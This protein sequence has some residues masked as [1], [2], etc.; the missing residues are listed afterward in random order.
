[1]ASSLRLIPADELGALP[2]TEILSGTR[3][4]S[5]GLNVIFGASGAF[6]SFYALD[7]ALTVAQ[8]AP[9]VYVAAEGAGGLHRRVTSWC[10]YN[11]K[12][13]GQLF[14]ICKEINLLESASVKSLLTIT[15]PVKPQL[16]VFD[17]L[18]RCIP[19]GDEN[20]AKD[21]GI[22]IQNSAVVQRE[23]NTAV[24]WVHHTNRAERGER[25]SGAIRG[26]ADAM[27]EISANG[28]NVIRVACSKL[29]D[30]EPWA[31]EELQFHS[32][33]RS[34]VLVPIGEFRSEKLSA[35][36]YQILDFLAL[37]VF[38]TSGAKA[39][40]IVNGVNIPERKIYHILSHLKREL[41]ISHDSK[42]DPYRLTESGRK[43]V[44]Q[45]TADPAKILQLV[46]PNIVVG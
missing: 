31:M 7:A 9:V 2:P 34:G 28:D 38:E 14:F 21:T 44:L 29:K 19:G 46:Q 36:E 25:G 43:L 22:A 17:T 42:G 39:I 45:R 24:A 27:I 10:D 35:Q 3:L 41:H 13:P 20:S 15:H 1:L 16:M 5:R 8:A 30:D 12:D 4:I 23:L 18:A 37:E 11:E 26:A 33:G 32:V 6:K 40:Q